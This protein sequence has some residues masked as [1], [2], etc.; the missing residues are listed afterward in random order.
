MRYGI[1]RV[2]DTQEHRWVRRND[3][4]FWCEYPTRDEI[5]LNDR[6]EMA[7][8]TKTKTTVAEVVKEHKFPQ[9]L[10]DWLV[11]NT[12]TH[13]S[14]NGRGC[15][16][17]S[18]HGVVIPAGKGINH[19]AITDYVIQVRDLEKLQRGLA[20]KESALPKERVEIID[21]NKLPETD[22][23]P[24]PGATHPIYKDKVA[25]YWML[26]DG[27][28]K[29]VAR[30]AVPKS[31]KIMPDKKKVVEVEALRKKITKTK[32]AISTFEKKLK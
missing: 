29:R 26:L 30:P 5:P 21:L 10:A 24:K 31:V 16:Y 6:K 18:D 22:G 9:K 11:K 20:S 3:G 23:E 1:G 8:R 13:E 19:Y 14:C 25:G 2:H 28:W 32:R 4:P 7:I 27:A 17:C 15:Y 12:A